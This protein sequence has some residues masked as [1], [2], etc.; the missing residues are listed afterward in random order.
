MIKEK[1]HKDWGMIW[2]VDRRELFDLPAHEFRDAIYENRLL[3]IKNV[4]NLTSNEIYYLMDKFGK[5]WNENQYIDSQERYEIDYYRDQKFVVT[6]FSN[7]TTKKI[8]SKEMPFHADIPN[9]PD[10]PFPHRF[11]YMNKQPSNLYGRTYWLNIDLDLLNLENKELNY[12]KDCSVIQQSWWEPGTNLQKLSFIKNHP[13]VEGRQSLRLNYYV[14]PQ[15]QK[16]AWILECYHKDQKLDNRTFLGTIIDKLRSR[17]E[18]MY[19]HT[20]DEGDMVIYDNWSFIHGRTP[21][22]LQENEIREFIRA[23]ID[24]VSDEDFKNKDFFQL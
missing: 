11:L 2:K 3:V 14:L 20:W 21:L 23:N 19:T 16:D 18:L 1:I 5:P 9:H 7:K 17:P 22:V 6:R 8:K 4:G 24:H 13:I 10:R 12:Y 15:G